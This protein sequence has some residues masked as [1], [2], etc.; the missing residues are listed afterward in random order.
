MKLLIF[1]SLFSLLSICSAIGIDFEDLRGKSMCYLLYK[2]LVTRIVETISSLSIKGCNDSIIEC[3]TGYFY[4]GDDTKEEAELKSYWKIATT[5]VYSCYKRLPDLTGINE[6]LE[7]CYNS[8]SES[9]NMEARVVSFEAVDEV[10]R[11]FN[12]ILDQESDKRP[13]DKDLPPY[14]VLTSAMSFKMPNTSD[15]QWIYLG[16][17]KYLDL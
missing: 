6:G 17:S 14:V 15:S 10:E 2:L 9:D 1:I 16:T 4:A 11:V 8:V 3:P 12:Y 13:I 7:K 5:P